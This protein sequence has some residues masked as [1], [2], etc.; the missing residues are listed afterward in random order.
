MV[1]IYYYQLTNSVDGSNQRKSS[2]IANMSAADNDDGG[3]HVMIAD[4]MHTFYK[5]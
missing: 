2:P 3:V 5:W 1:S 4:G